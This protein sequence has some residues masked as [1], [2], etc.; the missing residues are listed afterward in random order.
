MSF[1]SDI[2]GGMRDCILKIFW[3]KDHIVQFFNNNGCTTSDISSL[4]TYKEYPRYKIVD[5]MFDHLSAKTDGGLGPFRAMLQA[6][7]N[8]S[9]FDPYYFDKLSKLNKNEAQRSIDHL[10]QLQE[11]RDYKIQE[12]RKA[13]AAKQ[14]EFKNQKNIEELK[15]K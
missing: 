1:P 3:P 14:A 6:L 8:W 9:H 11:I 15:L 4:G 12:D 13:R 2:K 10:R 7:T 5:Q